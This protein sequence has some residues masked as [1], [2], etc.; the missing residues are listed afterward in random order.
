MVINGRNGEV[1]VLPQKV[2][3]RYF[4]LGLDSGHAPPS[5]PGDEFKAID[6]SDQISLGGGERRA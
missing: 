3:G 4:R 5:D 1:C 2:H 6:E